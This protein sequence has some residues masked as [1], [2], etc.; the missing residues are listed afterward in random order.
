M[1]NLIVL[2]Y[3]ILGF[4]FLTTLTTQAQEFRWARKIGGTL[5][6][7]ITDQT[8][9]SQNDLIISGHTNGIADLD[10][11]ANYLPLHGTQTA[12]RSFITKLD[13]AGNVVWIDTFSGNST[14]YIYIHSV[15]TDQSDNVYATGRFR[16][17]I[18]FD[19]SANV[20]NQTATNNSTGAIFFLKLSPQG[21]LLWVKVLDGTAMN[22]NQGFDIIASRESGILVAGTFGNGSIDFD[23]G[24]GVYNLSAPARHIFVAKYDYQGELIWAKSYGGNGP[25]ESCVMD[26]D[27]EGNIYLTGQ[28]TPNCDFDPGPGVAMP[29]PQWGEKLYVSKWDKDG[30]F[31][32]VNCFVGI[33]GS[34]YSTDIK[35]DGDSSI[36][37]V[38]GI[39]GSLNFNEQGDDGVVTA[40][41]TYS[42]FILKMDTAGNFNWVIPIDRSTAYSCAVDGNKDVYVTG[43]FNSGIVDF[44]PGPNTHIMTAGNFVET[45][46]AKYTRDKELAWAKSFESP[47]SAQGYC[48]A[49][50][51]ATNIYTSGTFSGT[52]DLNPGIGVDT[53]IADG[54]DIFI[55]K[56]TQCF[57]NR[58][59]NQIGNTLY[60]V[61]SF[62]NYS[63]LNCD[64]NIVIAG[65]NLGSYT[66]VHTGNYAVILDKGNGCKDT[67]DCL[68]VFVEVDTTNSIHNT[69]LEKSLALYP[70]PS[71]GTINY[72]IDNGILINSIAI[73]DI[74]GRNIEQMAWDKSN[75][76]IVLP[77][78]KGM[79]WLRLNT[80]KGTIVKKIVIA[81]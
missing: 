43:Y 4:V 31:I 11:G 9:D 53:F 42:S 60:A 29:Y 20:A 1:K 48:I 17:T 5:S 18:D 58:G 80:D 66:P 22:I 73:T 34:C 8:F 14:S 65:A 79:F 2:R 52:S 77:N 63:W 35:Y 33:G 69:I 76:T 25:E 46:I 10:P 23:P 16:G 7:T 62:V 3:L 70:N 19:P 21:A 30:N 61:A 64:S 71:T 72:R 40:V 44:D 12:L 54:T 26:T 57:I 68:Y 47:G 78:Q 28:F 24:P 38:G 50:D 74:T 81:P 55:Q 41:G 15:T 56:M 75:Q 37:L 45:Y 51:K 6:Q 39:N 32:R 49:L 36:Y 59:I 67:S 27:N 13:T